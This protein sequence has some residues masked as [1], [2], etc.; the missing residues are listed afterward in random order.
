MSGQADFSKER[1]EGLLSRI[2]N[3][4]KYFNEKETGADK[5]PDHQGTTA[6]INLVKLVCSLKE[7]EPGEAS[8]PDEAVRE[9]RRI[10]MEEYGVRL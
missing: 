5:N 6:Y 3:Y 1:L 2:R 10:F 9:A 8:D 4:E 7:S